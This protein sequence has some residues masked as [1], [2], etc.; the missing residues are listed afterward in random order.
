LKE[1]LRACVAVPHHITAFFIPHVIDSDPLATGSLGAGLIVDP[2]AWSCYEPSAGALK[3]VLARVARLLS[4]K[5]GVRVYEPLPAMRGYGT[6]AAVSLSAALSIAVARGSSLLEA[7]QAAHV[8][9]VGERTGLGDVLALWGASG[10]VAVRL[11][12]GAPGL[13][14]V[15]Y[16]HAPPN[17]VAVTASKGEEATHSLLTRL[18]ESDIAEAER[19]LRRLQDSMSFEAFVEV[20]TEFSGRTGWMQRLLGPTAGEALRLEGVLGGYAKKR[21][22]VFLVESDRALDLAGLLEAR[23]FEVRLHNLWRG[24]VPL[25]QWVPE[26][27]APPWR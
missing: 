23:G 21:V 26:S 14:V 1:D 7:A 19:A 24:A 20:A 9:E 18:R 17:I 3:G 13:G 22:A 4:V 2:L 11:A 5:G 12:P 8:A 10:P 27:Q 25:V 6:S 16:I 15:D